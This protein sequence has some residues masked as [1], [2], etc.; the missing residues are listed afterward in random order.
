M[1]V[2]VKGVFCAGNICVRNVKFSLRLYVIRE[3]LSRVLCFNIKMHTLKYLR[4][5]PN[6]TRHYSSSTLTKIYN[7]SSKFN[8]RIS[9]LGQLRK[10][11][12]I[13]QSRP[14]CYFKNSI[15]Y[16]DSI[17]KYRYAT[18]IRPFSTKKG[19]PETVAE[20]EIEKET[21][22]NHTQL[23]APVAV[24]EVW[25]QLP[26]I[27]INRNPVFPRF[28]KLIEVRLIWCNNIFY[29]TLDYELCTY[30]NRNLEIL[31]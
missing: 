8:E 12:Y 5:V 31:C 25:P 17:L 27:A 13:Y 6:L 20:P 23:P 9:E 29:V 10:T 30:V 22:T 3:W 24:P 21:T 19:D 1:L 28:I 18:N 16:R 26:V 7:N 11:L 4:R 15:K 2:Y 14:L